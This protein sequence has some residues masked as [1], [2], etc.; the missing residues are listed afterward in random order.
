MKL[1]PIRLPGA[2]AR[3]VRAFANEI[4]Q[5]RAQGYTFEAIREALA[6]AGVHVS[7]STVQREAA[8]AATPKAPETAIV[9]GSLSDHPTRRAAKAIEPATVAQGT[10][11]AVVPV[12]A[13]SGKDIAEA[14]VRARSTN[15]L[16]RAKE[17]L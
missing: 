10:T 12:E 1:V 7:N 3:K 15:P 2:N 4:R 13:R 9:V 17:H 6:A 16:I 11:S 5:L 8:R 14:F